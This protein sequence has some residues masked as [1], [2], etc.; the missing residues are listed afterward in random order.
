[1]LSYS[2]TASVLAALATATKYSGDGPVIYDSDDMPIVEP[3][4][5]Y[6]FTIENKT[7][8]TVQ[9]TKPIVVEGINLPTE[10]G[11]GL[12]VA[13]CVEAFE[14]APKYIC[15]YGLLFDGDT[16]MF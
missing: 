1:M 11:T 16:L 5:E 2:F 9:T 12:Q 10:S 14:T 7:V 6:E 15:Y 13:S 4:L 8:Q 3:K